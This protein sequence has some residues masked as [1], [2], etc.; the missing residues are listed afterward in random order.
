MTRPDVIA[1]D[2]AA[3]DPTT[4]DVTGPNALGQNALGQN[5]P[6]PNAPDHDATDAP[7][8]PR[9]ERPASFLARTGRDLTTPGASVNL[10]VTRASTFVFKSMQEFETAAQKPFD[11]SFYGRVGTPV[12]MAF[13]R[14]LAEMEGGYRA[15]ATSSGVAAC[16]G[17]FLAFLSQGD[18]VLVPDSVYDPVRRFC[19]RTLGRMGIEATFYDPSI[20]AGID[21]LVRENTRFIYMESPG[22][23]T[24]EVQDVPAIVAVAKARGLR[25][26]IDNTWA[27]PLYFKPLTLGVDASVHAATKYI[28]GHSDAML[29]V[30]ITN[31][32]T[33]PAIRAA[34]QDTGACAGSE[35]ANL[36]LRG[37][38]TLDLRLTRHF[39]SG[40][41]VASWL[42]GQPQVARVLHPALPSFAGHA[43][44]KRDFAGA[45]GLFSFELKP[46]AAGQTVAAFTDVLTYFKIGFSWGGFESLVLPAHPEKRTEPVWTGQGPLVRLHI[47]LEDPED[48]IADLAQALAGLQLA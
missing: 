19:Q 32:E 2:V 21:A 7:A 15:I 25:T 46:L 48:L 41:K 47:G 40:V 38:R 12:S 22:S 44:W 5:V 24:F 27:T 34:L 36:G 6:C 1:A 17:V 23:G 18:H 11:N 42:E 20:G 33:F 16:F 35:E 29:G 28:T 9:G 10:P 4:P 39:D 13:E 26:A 8:P 3:A 30:V 14:S 45:C 37:L 43:L 31:E